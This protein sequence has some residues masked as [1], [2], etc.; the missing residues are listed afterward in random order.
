MEQNPVNSGPQAAPPKHFV[1]RLVIIAENRL[2]LLMLEVQEERERLLRAILLALSVATPGLLAGSFRRPKAPPSRG[3]T[4]WLQT[5][6]KVAG[7]VSTLWVLF[8]P[9]AR[10]HEEK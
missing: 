7:V 10:E 8:R 3:T 4:S 5:I 9:Q 2:E 1:R 6:L